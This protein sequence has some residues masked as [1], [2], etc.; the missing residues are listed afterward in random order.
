MAKKNVFF[1]S[2]SIV[3]WVFLIYIFLFEKNTFHKNQSLSHDILLKNLSWE[4]T[5][6]WS[7]P[8][9]KWDEI[10][11]TF[12]FPWDGKNHISLDKNKWSKNIP[13]K[14]ILIDDKITP[15]SKIIIEDGETLKIIWEANQDG[16]LKKEDFDDIILEN[17]K[18]KKEEETENKEKSFSGSLDII[19]EKNTLSSHI[20]HL[21][22]ISWKDKEMIQYLNIWWNSFTP[23]QNNGKVYLAIEKNTFSSGEYFIL[24]QLEN[25]EIVSLDKK[26]YFEYWASQVNI[27]NITPNNIKN[28][29]DTF[30]VLQGNGF[31]KVI[32]IQLSN[33]IILKNTSFDII[34]DSVMSVKIP[35]GLE[36]G[37]YYFN[38]MT[39]NGI[40][41]LKQNSFII[42]D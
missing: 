10:E 24:I 4:S 6:W 39:V 21:I 30:L 7:I 25:G 12:I 42:N 31:S 14:K 26:F 15:S 2:L 17:E 27:A 13:I 29:Q 16:I 33:N 18:I 9:K 11:V 28:T 1:L 38:I 37:K 36:S 8:Y 20:N 41:E 3:L 35:S 34:N 19:F 5:L 40:H 23:I 32:S 22:E